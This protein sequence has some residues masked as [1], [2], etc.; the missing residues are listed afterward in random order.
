VGTLVGL[1]MGIIQ[2]T[3]W[4]N[5]GWFLYGGNTG[6]CMDAKIGSVVIWG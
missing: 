4:G 3:A 2:V 1:C 6:Y 5:T